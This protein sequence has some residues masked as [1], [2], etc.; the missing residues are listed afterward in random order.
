[1]RQLLKIE[2]CQH[3]AVTV[4]GGAEPY[5]KQGPLSAQVLGSVIIS[6]CNSSGFY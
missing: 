3:N 2:T 6:A 4:L 1:M 5:Q